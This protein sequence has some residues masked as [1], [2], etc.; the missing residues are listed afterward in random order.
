MDMP[1]SRYVELL[2][3]AIG[4]ALGVGVTIIVAGG[5]VWDSHRCPT[6]PYGEISREKMCL[7]SCVCNEVRL[8][9]IGTETET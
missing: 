5:Q 2:S 7:R 1:L 4:I 9:I 3:A 6:T 8:F